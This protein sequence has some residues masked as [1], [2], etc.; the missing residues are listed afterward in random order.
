MSL[1]ANIKQK[2]AMPKVCCGNYDKHE[3]PLIED[4]IKTAF[5]GIDCDI[6]IVEKE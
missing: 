6:L 4:I 2:I 1:A 3:W 5:V